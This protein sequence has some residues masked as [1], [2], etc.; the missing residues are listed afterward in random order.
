MSL[1][2]LIAYR[3]ARKSAAAPLRA[4]HAGL[5]HFESACGS[6]VLFLIGAA[7]VLWGVPIV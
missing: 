3:T 5:S 1:I 7:S 6:I 4:D 2:K